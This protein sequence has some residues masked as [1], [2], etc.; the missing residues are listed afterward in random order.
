MP[1]R[2]YNT[3]SRRI[4]EFR[5]S[6][7]E[8]RV[9]VCGVTPY[10]TTHLGHAF[11]YVAFDVLIRYLRF[12]GHPLRYIQNIT[13]VDNDILRR[14]REKGE[15]WDDLG[16]RYVEIHKRSLGALGVVPPDK[17]PRASEEIAAI[18]GIIQGLLA[19]QHAYVADGNVYFRV[20]SYASYGDLSRL[21][22][23]EMAARLTETGDPVDD[24]RKER[25]LD[26]LLWQAARPGE[27]SWTSPWGTGRPGW[28]IECSAMAMRYL[29]DTLDIHGGGS[30]LIYPHHESEI[31]QSESWSGRRPFARFWVHCGLV[32][33]NGEKMSKSLGNMVFVESLLQEHEPD[34]IRVYLLSVHYRD[35]LHYDES[36][37]RASGELVNRLRDAATL[38]EPS[39]PVGQLDATP[40]RERFLAALDDDLDTPTSIA[41]LRQLGEEIV[42]ARERGEAVNAA[43]EQLRMLADILGLRLQP[44]A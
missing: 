6:D 33:M 16:N 8:V 24:P 5:P 12:L 42:A 13:D 28:H 11:C 17:Y 18:I 2:L 19:G 23:E 14:A 25:P 1:L 26:F 29:G 38:E 15:R 40:H 27:P 36:A 44:L 3:L 31:A 9:Y 30:D 4:E 37:L 41:T 10:D 21:K 32:Q 39:N 35:A 7:H 20:S 22:P 34:G 43:Q